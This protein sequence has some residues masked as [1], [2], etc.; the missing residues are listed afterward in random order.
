MYLEHKSTS[1]SPTYVKIIAYD[2]TTKVATLES[3]VTVIAGDRY[4]LRYSLPIQRNTLS[5]VTSSTSVT[6]PVAGAN[7]TITNMYLFI[8]TGA[9][10]GSY[11]LISSVNTTTGVLQLAS[12]LAV[13]PAPGDY[14]SVFPF[15]FDSYSPL[16]YNGTTTNNSPVCYNVVLVGVSIPNTLIANGYR[17]VACDYP[18]FY[19]RLYNSNAKVGGSNIYSNN[20]GSEL[21]CFKVITYTSRTDTNF[22]IYVVPEVQTISIR[23]DD[24]L[25]F[26]LTLPD[27]SPVEWQESDNV[28]PAPVNPLLQISATFQ[29]E[30][31][32]P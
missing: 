8:E 18:Y 10:A 24:N 26:E 20:P 32:A 25:F 31:L 5:A 16:L 6:I 22:F 17:S 28:P 11:A 3:A 15:S 30:R 9:A 29:L 2:G 1:A 13:L 19:I 12:P 4:S 7:K 23:I 21:A 14:Y 27:G